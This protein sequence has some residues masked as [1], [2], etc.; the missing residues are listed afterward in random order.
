MSKFSRMSMSG[1]LLLSA[2]AV[3]AASPH[4]AARHYSV[5]VLP[6]LGG[7]FV[8]AFGLNNRGQVTGTSATSG[9]VANHPFLYT[10][11]K[12]QDLGTP[13]GTSGSGIAVNGRGQVTGSFKAG[14]DSRQ[15]AFIFSGGVMKDLGMQSEVSVGHSINAAGEVAGLS[16]TLGGGAA[17]HLHAVVFSGGAIQDLGTLGAD[18][19]EA[20]DVNE[21]LGINDRGQVTGFAIGGGNQQ[22]HAFLYTNGSMMDLGTLGGTSSGGSAVNNRGQVVG[23]STLTGNMTEH[24]FLY[25]NG[26]MEDLGTLGGSF[27]TGL[28]VN[29]HGVVTGGASIAGEVEHAFVGSSGKMRDLNDEIGSAALL[30]TLVEGEAI[31][32]KGQIVVNGIIN[33]TGTQAAFLLTPVP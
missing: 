12:M 26:L 4:S 24:A 28:A 17:P 33:Q 16:G 19:G 13:D 21:A 23:A 9:D 22:G 3:G 30:Y 31:N 10:D 5:T 25:H 20:L 29:S 2:S 14:H 7:T 32:D 6:T 8:Q 27:S 1:L 11:G 18:A 15:H